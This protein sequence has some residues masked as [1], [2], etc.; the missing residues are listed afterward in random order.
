MNK[1]KSKIKMKIKFSISLLILS[2]S[3]LAASLT[4]KEPFS[5]KCSFNNLVILNSINS[6]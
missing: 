3:F 5:F 4:Y 6:K 2:T 1:S